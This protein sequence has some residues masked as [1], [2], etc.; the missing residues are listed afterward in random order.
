MSD[1]DRI[2]LMLQVKDGKLTM[3]DAL[4]K[5]SILYTHFTLLTVYMYT[6]LS[7]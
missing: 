2:E 7:I 1:E 6:V 4:T 3:V 5:V